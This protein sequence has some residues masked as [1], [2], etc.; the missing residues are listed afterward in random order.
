MSDQVWL[1]N[2]FEQHRRYLRSVAVRMLGSADEA[3]DAVQE[4][5]LRL[6]RQDNE[7][8]E[9]LRAWLTTVVGRV[10]LDMLRSRKSR[11]EE[12]LSAASPHLRV[13]RRSVVD[14]ELE[15]LLADSV[16]L[17]LVVILETMAPAE[18]VAFVLHDMFEFPFDEI[19]PIVGRTSTATRKLASRARQKLHGAR[20]RVRRRD[21]AH[22]EAIVAAFLSAS[23]NGSFD[24]LLALLDPSTVFSADAVAAAAGFPEVLRGGAAVAEAFSGAARGAQLALIDGSPGMVW[25]PHGRPRG[26]FVFRFT[27][28]RI[29]AIDLVGEPRQ[30]DK[31]HIVILPAPGAANGIELAGS[32]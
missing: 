3:E 20:N 23:K 21:Q 18:R 22:R 12:S 27:R 31:L 5:W 9:N 13:L 7:D 1:A 10:C 6:S 15:A 29:S 28:T 25:A 4:A 14:P 26:A 32:S 2:G 16:G 24:A 11:R 30:V 19:A 17:A 8:I